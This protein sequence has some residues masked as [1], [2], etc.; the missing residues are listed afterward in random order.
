MYYTAY[1][2]TMYEEEQ[3]A[4][5]VEEQ[6]TEA[7]QHQIRTATAPPDPVFVRPSPSDGESP[8]ILECGCQL[9]NGKPCFESL[10]IQAIHAMRID[11]QQL[12]HD[13]LDMVILGQIAAS[14]QSDTGKTN[15]YFNGQRIC[16]TMF[17]HLHRI[18]LKRLRTLLQHYKKKGIAP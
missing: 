11:I 4:D 18:S 8:S 7:L 5:D 1:K 3:P 9:A 13:E 15:F 16:Q 2:T 6:V 12:S 14:Y 17:L 10:N